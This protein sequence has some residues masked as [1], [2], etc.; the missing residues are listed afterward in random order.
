MQELKIHSEPAISPKVLMI[1]LENC[2]SQI[3]GLLDQ[4]GQYARVVICY[5]QSGA[6]VPLDWLPALSET[7]TSGRLQIVRMPSTGKNAADFGISFFA[8]M[9]AQQLPEADFTI[10]SNDGDLDHVVQLL[11]SLKHEA[12]RSGHKPASA[13]PSESAASTGSAL[14]CAPPKPASVTPPE[15]KTLTTFCA[16]IKAH[17]HN[18][19]NK[20]DSLLNALKSHFSQ[21]DAL[22]QHIFNQL[23][24]I[25]VIE[26]K[27]TKIIFDD[28]K[29]A[30]W[31]P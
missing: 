15:G 20:V 21:S 27:D 5:A 25:G 2:P 16:Q 31:A 24:Q 22:A 19:P 8:G 4:L 17:P 23:K 28:K 13:S 26:V 18:R 9:L 7:L 12:K 29:L 1:D 6:K 11:H 30:E 3:N 10:M 14:C